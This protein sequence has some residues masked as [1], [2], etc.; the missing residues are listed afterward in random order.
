LLR[1]VGASRSQ[2]LV[3]VAVEALIIGVLASLAGIIIGIGLAAGLRAMLD[4]TGFSMPGGPLVIKPGALIISFLVGVLVTLPASALPAVKASRV[5]PLAAMRDVA[6]ERVTAAR[7]R[8]IAGFV[9]AALGVGLVAGGAAAESLQLAGFG[10]LLALAAMVLLGPVVA[11]P[12]SQALGYPLVRFRGLV[13]SLARRN[14]MRNPRRTA[15]TASALMVGVAVVTLFTVFAASLKAEVD[16][17]TSRSFRGDLVIAAASFSGSGLSPQLSADIDALPEV[18]TATG[19]GNGV[20]ELDGDSHHVTVA[21]PSTMNAVLDLDVREG[22]ISQMRDDGVAISQRYA[23][24]NDLSLGD[25]FVVRF[26]DGATPELHVAAIYEDAALVDDIVIPVSLWNAHA[27]QPSEAVVLIKLANG[28]GLEEGRAAVE[29]VAEAYSAPDVQDREEFVDSVAANVDQFLAVIYVLLALAIFIALMGIANTL[30]LSI[31][32][33][34][35]ELGLLRA[36]G[37]TRG[38]LRAMVRGE[39]MIVALFGTLGGLVLGVFLGWG[40]V[41]ALASEGI[42]SFAV[43][44]SQLLIVF[45]VGAAAGVL[46]GLRPARRAAKLPVLDAISGI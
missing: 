43:P 45:V 39:S 38:Q 41:R 16:S 18:G 21:D 15:G 30:S 22:A 19:L 3:A 11:S 6:T 44:L 13:G 46:A 26:A 7:A 5:P 33:R 10:A 31:H 17:A 28:V 23:D 1:A 32:E 25:P 20:V 27:T 2:I 9:C 24:D 40:L 36:V 8:R 29:R 42:E 4:A 14:A 35:R 37:E 34:T 12:A